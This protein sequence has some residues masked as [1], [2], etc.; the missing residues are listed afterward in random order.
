MKETELEMQ[1][2]RLNIGA[3]VYN[4]PKRTQ[5]NKKAIYTLTNETKQ[6]H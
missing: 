3:C 2:A 4:S 1:K 5:L 6:Y